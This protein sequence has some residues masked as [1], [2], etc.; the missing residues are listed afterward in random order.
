MRTT[1]VLRDDL[2][3]SAKKRAAELN[4]TL[5]AV[6][7]QALMRALMEPPAFQPG[8]PVHLP[9]YAPPKSEKKDTRPEELL[10]L[11]AEE[12]LRSATG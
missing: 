9:T 8:T 6:V 5:S 4:L 11:M 1:L 12:D 10:E 7:D 2:V 3:K